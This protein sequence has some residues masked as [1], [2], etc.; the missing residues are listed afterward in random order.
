[1][2]CLLIHS[3]LLQIITFRSSSIFNRRTLNV[4]GQLHALIKSI[5]QFEL[6]RVDCMFFR[7]LLFLV[8][9][10]ALYKL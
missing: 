5:A 6:Y 8:G 7:V 3:T 4:E 10:W 9:Q 1:M 2:Q